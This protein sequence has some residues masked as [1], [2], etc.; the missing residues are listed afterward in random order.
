F[1]LGAGLAELAADDPA[2]HTRLLEHAFDWPPLHYIISNAATSVASSDEEIMGWYAELADD[3]GRSGAILESIITERRQTIAALES[4]YGGPLD[5]RRPNHARTLDLRRPGLTLVHRLQVN[6][7]RRWRAADEDAA[8]AMIPELLLTV[9][10][11]AGGLG[12]T[13]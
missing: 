10:A 9:N 4:I 1:G 11:I 8:E 5:E 6:Q 12:A 2:G 7:L 3:G 13:G